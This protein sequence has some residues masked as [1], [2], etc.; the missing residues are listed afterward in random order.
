MKQAV[1]SL[2][3]TL[4]FLAALVFMALAAAFWKGG[5]QLSILGLTQASQLIQMVWLRVLLGFTLGGLIQV[6]LP[7]DL[8]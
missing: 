2:D 5:W 4:L 6:L 8:I 3:K 7:R 1:K